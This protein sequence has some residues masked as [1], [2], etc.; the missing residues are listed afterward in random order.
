MRNS[1]VLAI[2]EVEHVVTGFRLNESGEGSGKIEKK[3][4]AED[5]GKTRE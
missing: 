5:Q 4:M 1:R 2:V 3:K